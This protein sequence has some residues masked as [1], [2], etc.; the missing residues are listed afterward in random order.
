MRQRGWAVSRLGPSNGL[1]RRRAR[2][3]H[4]RWR[5]NASRLRLGALHRRSG[6]HSARRSL[7]GGIC[8]RRLGGDDAIDHAPQRLASNAAIGDQRL[9]Q[10]CEPR[11]RDAQTDLHEPCDATVDTAEA[12]VRKLPIGDSATTA[13]LSR[14]GG[15]TALGQ[16]RPHCTPLRRRPGCFGA[17]PPA[18]AACRTIRPLSGWCAHTH[19]TQREGV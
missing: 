2:C 7:A 15:S 16:H 19:E 8:R 1:G 13:A 17:S 14:R 4:S 5:R 9:R 3:R 18:A 11:R 10:F 12:S 6:A